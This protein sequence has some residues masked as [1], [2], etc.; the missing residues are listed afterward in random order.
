MSAKSGFLN[1]LGNVITSSIGLGAL[2]EDDS[3]AQLRANR[4]RQRSLEKLEEEKEYRKLKQEALESMAELVYKIKAMEG[5]RMC[6]KWQL[7]PFTRPLALC[8]RSSACWHRQLSSGNF[9][10]NRNASSTGL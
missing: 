8:R 4:W 1:R 3:S 10:Y 2:F 5:E 6:L 9:I 7:M